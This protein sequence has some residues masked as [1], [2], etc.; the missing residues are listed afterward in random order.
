L[1]IIL[2]AVFRQRTLWS[3]QILKN[4]F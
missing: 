3:F 1:C 2:F 4:S